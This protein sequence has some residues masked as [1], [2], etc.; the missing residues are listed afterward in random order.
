LVVPDLSQTLDDDK[1]NDVMRTRMDRYRLMMR[2]VLCLIICSAVQGYAQP[3]YTVTDLGPAS[4]A[5]NASF[6]PTAFND[7]GVVVGT[8]SRHDGSY[9]ARLTGGA[10]EVLDREGYALRINNRGEA[11]GWAG[12]GASFHGFIWDANG[13]RFLPVPQGITRSKA[14]GINESSQ[15]SMSVELADGSWHAAR[16]QGGSLTLLP[17]LRAGSG[18]FNL[19]MAINNRGDVA[20]QAASPDWHAVI[21]DTLGTLIDLGGDVGE[22]TAINDARQVTGTT[23]QARAFRAEIGRGLTLIPLREGYTFAISQD[24]DHDGTVVGVMLQPDTSQHPLQVRWTPD[25]QV[26]DL[27]QELDPASGWVLTSAV[28]IRNG[29]I[30]G[31]GWRQGVYSQSN[32]VLLTPIAAEP[33]SLAIRLNQET[34]GP[35]E[36]LRMA[37]A[38]RNPGPLLTTDVY[39]GVILPDGQTVLWLTN[40][41]PLAGVVT[42]LDSNPSTFTPMLRN[43]SWPAGLD[44]TQEGYLSYR[45]TGGEAPGVYH[46]LVGW[47]TPGSLADGRIDEGDV[48]AL[49]WKTIQ[50]TGPA[51]VLAAQ[52]RD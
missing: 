24:I 49:D 20:I 50:F 19:A 22:V 29:K 27:N 9:P 16:A 15:V 36:T 31:T 44:V 51:S 6:W 42:R 33:P 1:E 12:V 40:T 17:S 8:L 14:S 37:L 52:A 43:A 30:L 28:A 3:R 45:F 48:L 10:L 38:L 35:G 5:D 2:L 34:F 25:G 23:S 47:T 26:V 39:V 21:A 41:A 11:V 18:Y 32:V 7:R 4:Y 13:W 46:L